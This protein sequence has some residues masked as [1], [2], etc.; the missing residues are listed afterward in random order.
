MFVRNC[1]YV[2][3]WTEELSADFLT[4]TIINEPIVIYRK[5]DNSLVAL[6][7]RCAHRMAP[8]SQGKRQGDDIRCMYHGLVFS[9]S[10]NCIEI[11]GQDKIPARLCVK[12]YPVVE[13]HSWIWVWMGDPELADEDLI[14][15]AHG[16]ANNEWYLPHNHLDYETNYM[17]ICDN[18]TDFSHLGYVH[19][20]SFGS[21]EQWAQKAPTIT[22][23]DRGIRMSRWL[24]SVAPI[25]P[26]GEAAK[27]QAVDHW[28]TYD[29]LVP[30]VLIFYNALYPVGTAEKA[31]NEAPTEAL[32]TPLYTHYSIQAVTPKTD[33][34]T[35]YLYCWGP[36][37]SLG[38]EEEA[39]IMRTIL[40]KAFLED[41]VII[42]AQHKVIQFDPTRTAVSILADKGVVMFQRTIERMIQEE[43]KLIPLAAVK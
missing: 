18:L 27:H 35:R 28:A 5:S 10:G 22:Q 6:E 23:L 31:N 40:L 21:D 4:C 37:K 29:F 14:P 42:E 3:A 43:N 12:S 41:Q 26:L 9:P 30:G 11:P 20:Q 1:W 38:T 34:S 15:P 36:S 32:G 24:K 25:P 2:A 16:G 19:T 13:R 8:L 39:E 17:L 7:D 33:K